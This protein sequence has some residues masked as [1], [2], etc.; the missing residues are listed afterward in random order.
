MAAKTTSHGGF[1]YR[2][3]QLFAMRRQP[4]KQQPFLVVMPAP[5]QPDKARVLV[6]PN[7]LDAKGTTA[8][9][10]FVPSPDG[11]LVA[12]SLSKGGT[13]TGD[14]HVYDTD[15]G[16]GGLRGR[17]AR[18]RRHGRRRPGLGAGRQGLLLHAL[19]ARQGAPGRG[20]RLLPAG[21]FP[22]AG[23]ADGEGPLRD[24]ART[25]RA[26]P[27]SSWK[28]TTPP[29]ACWPRCRTA[30]A[31]SSPSSC[32]NRTA[33]GGNSAPSRTSWCRPPSAATTTCS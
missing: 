10:W 29:A 26:S 18:Q 30:T 3:G 5:D 32:A 6:D 25:C 28:R 22:R 23:H 14:V 2:G 17:A 21:L 7:E 20:H 31:A 24:W 13:E 12:V 15:D 4:P 11:K 19:P 8:I 33:N 16:Q 1:S 27:R 9:D